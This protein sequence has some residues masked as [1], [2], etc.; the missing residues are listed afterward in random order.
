MVAYKDKVERMTPEQLAEFILKD[1]ICKNCKWWK[2]FGN[3]V[4][5]CENKTV[6]GYTVRVSFTFGTDSMCFEP[7]E[8]FGCNQWEK[9]DE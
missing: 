5:Q 8:T 6:L 2:S 1:R 9:R 4:V 7:S 3:N